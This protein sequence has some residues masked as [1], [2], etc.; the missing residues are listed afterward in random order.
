[1][2]CR[3]LIEF[4][5]AYLAGE[6]TPEQRFDFDAHLA[7]CPPC[8]AYLRSYEETIRLGRDA[9]AVTDGEAPADMPEELVRAILAARER[10]RT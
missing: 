2:T 7:T 10:G 1:M 9:F 6:V 8:V 5:W 3:D 4:L